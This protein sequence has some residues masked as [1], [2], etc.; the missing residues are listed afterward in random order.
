MAEVPRTD[1]DLIHKW[2]RFRREQWL[3][4]WRQSRLED[5]AAAYA[6][7]SLA[8]LVK[9]EVLLDSACGLGQR[10]VLLARRGLNILGS[11]ISSSAIEGARQFAT[12]EGVPT[13]FFTASWAEVAR[14]APHRFDGILCT[15]LCLTSAWDELCAALGGLYQALRP[16][17]FLMFKGAGSSAPPDEGKRL[18]SAEWDH[19][20]HQQA[21]FLWREGDCTCGS[22]LFKHRAADYLDYEYIY[23]VAEKGTV[24]LESAIL[25]RPFYWTWKHWAEAARRAGFCHLE[26]RE[27]DLP[28]GKASFNVAWRSREGEV[29]V[30]EAGRNAPYA[31]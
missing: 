7:A 12:A 19:Q 23:L 11:D 15:G 9:A 14:A 30:D 21:K 5:D 2:E 3:P 6:F 16:G 18:L 22:I 17:G 10:A 26:T 24:R 13:S 1:W 31:T 29:K 28:A 27:Y 25:R 20:P 4:Q 8:Q